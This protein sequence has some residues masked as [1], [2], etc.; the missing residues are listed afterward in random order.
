MS[1]HQIIPDGTGLHSR[2]IYAA[3]TL[4]EEMQTSRPNMEAIAEQAGM[5][6]EDLQ[7]LFV[8][9]HAVLIAAAEH[10]LVRLIDSSVKAVVKVDPEDA[11]GQFMALG[12]AYIDWAWDH[13]QQFRLLSDDRILDV[14]GTPQL[15]RYLNSLVDLMIKMLER[16]QEAGRLPADENIRL[17][18]LSSR[19]F[20]YGLVR[21]VVD[22]RMQEW[23]PEAP[24][25]EAAKLALQD[26]VQRIARGTI[27]GQ[28]PRP[29]R[30]P[31]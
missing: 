21:M 3:L 16:A 4:L 15:R 14:L 9:E 20:A 23:Y 7:R 11:V 13:R 1:K 2:A 22:G 19:T 10:A 18:V 28:R 31:A 25:V 26:F 6:L 8:D 24:P 29:A 5:P 12:E 30:Q 27:R 17:L